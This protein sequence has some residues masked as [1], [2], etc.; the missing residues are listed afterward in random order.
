MEP[1]LFT[2]SQCQ[3]CLAAH[4][5]QLLAKITPLGRFTPRRGCII[6]EAEKENSHLSAPKGGFSAPVIPGALKA[7][8]VSEGAGWFGFDVNWYLN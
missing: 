5:P 3:P 1:G 8:G 6:Y 7:L 2:G 4:F